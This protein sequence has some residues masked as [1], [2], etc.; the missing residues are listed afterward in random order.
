MTSSNLIGSWTYRSFINNPSPVDGDPD[1]AIRLF[2]A[3]AEFRFEAVSDTEFKG[4]IDWGSGGLDL[5]GTIKPGSADTP[6]AFAIVG[7]GRPGSQT[8]GWEY[9]YNGCLGYRWPNGIDQI[10]SLVGTVIRAKPHGSAPA[11][12]TASFIAVKRP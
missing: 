6:V 7:L 3:E 4:V 1:K 5:A 12:F 10:P 2:F 11:G 9:D 8:D